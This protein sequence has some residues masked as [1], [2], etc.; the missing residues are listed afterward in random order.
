MKIEVTLYCGDKLP[1]HSNVV[2]GLFKAE[3][4][5]QACWYEND[6][7]RCTDF[8]DG[9]CDTPEFWFE[10]P[11]VDQLKNDAMITAV[12]EY[13]FEKYGGGADEGASAFS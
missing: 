12:S 5:A 1:S 2:I 9:M 10:V 8:G 3:G 13:E 7:W 4:D 6:E 11:S